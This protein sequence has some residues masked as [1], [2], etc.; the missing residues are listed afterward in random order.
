MSHRQATNIC[1]YGNGCKWSKAFLQE[2]SQTPWKS[3]FRYICVDPSPNRPALPEWL[4]KVPTL[5]ISGEPEPRTDG[6]VM[7]WIYEKKM[8]EAVV[9]T[10]RQTNSVEGSPGGEPAAYSM[11][12]NT[13]FN[14]SFGYRFNSADTSTGGDGGSMIPGTFSFLN[15]NAAPGDRNSQEFPGSTNQT[16]RTKSKKEE[17]F[18]KQM[19]AYQRSREEG[20]PK[21]PAR[22]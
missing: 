13:S 11:F 22:Q 17:M 12:E 20:M 1:F 19:E 18:D 16:A 21:G 7:N 6:A 9:T 14:K 4:K 5:V 8:K 10:S 3:E 2:L 15:G